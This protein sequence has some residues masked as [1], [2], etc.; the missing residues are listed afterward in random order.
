[1]QVEHRGRHPQL[2]GG[3]GGGYEGEAMAVVEAARRE[4]VSYAAYNIILHRFV[5]DDEVVDES[6]DRHRY[7]RSVV[8]ALLASFP[9]RST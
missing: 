3:E 4:A 8:R 5:T 7:A 9:T 1:M 2:D 6:V